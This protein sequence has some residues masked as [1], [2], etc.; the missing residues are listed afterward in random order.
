MR[1]VRSLS[2]WSAM[3]RSPKRG[4]AIAGDLIAS[5][6]AGVNQIHLSD[7]R[8]HRS[9]PRR[10]HCQAG[11]DLR[12][13]RSVAPAVTG[14]ACSPA[15]NTVIV[16]GQTVITTVPRDSPTAGGLSILLCIVSRDTS[17]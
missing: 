1:G 7:A 11:P 12:K 15:T 4:A 3:E 5:Q 6:A 17:F 8:G 14:A 16:G 9:P 2:N 10:S 13:V